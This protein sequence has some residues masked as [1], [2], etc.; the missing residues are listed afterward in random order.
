VFWSFLSESGTKRKK[1]QK[2]DELI[3]CSNFGTLFVITF[4]LSVRF[5]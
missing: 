5:E 2:L 3:S 4:E 1:K